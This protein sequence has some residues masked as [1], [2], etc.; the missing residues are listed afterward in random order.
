MKRKILILYFV[1]CVLLLVTILYSV[2]EVVVKKSD[3]ELLD[4]YGMKYNSKRHAY[5][6][7]LLEKNWIVHEI[8]SSHIFWSDVQRR[9]DKI[10]PFHLY[11]I[12]FLKSGNIYNEKDAFHFE[13]DG[14]TAYRLMIWNY[15]NDRSLDSVQFRLITYF[16]NQYPPSETM[17]ITKEKADSIMFNWKQLSKSLNLE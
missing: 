16:K 15:F 1:F 2:R 10:E 3:L 12:T 17:V 14:G 11:K 13:T 5:N 4:E 9:V 6:I 8:D 7:P